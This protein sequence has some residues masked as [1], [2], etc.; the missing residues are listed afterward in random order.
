MVPPPV[1]SSSPASSALAAAAIEV[2]GGV[3]V[4]ALVSPALQPRL[5]SA[6]VERSSAAAHARRALRAEVHMANE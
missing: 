2:G 1:G 6:V 3:T 4:A 5:R